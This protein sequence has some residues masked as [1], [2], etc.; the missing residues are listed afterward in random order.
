MRLI[1]LICALVAIPIL[2]YLSLLRV[3]WVA[4]PQLEGKL[5]EGQFEWQGKLRS[6]TFFLPEKL[7]ANPGLVFVLHGSNG[8]SAAAR[9]G[10]AYE[11]DRLS[12]R[13]FIP[14]YPAGFDKHWND[15]RLEGPYEANLQ[16]IDDVGFLR[17]LRE[18]LLAE[19]IADPGRTYVTGISNGGQ[20]VYRLAL[21]APKTFQAYAAVIA[22][23]PAAENMAC[24]AAGEP[25]SMLVMN[26][27]E[28]PMNPYEGGMVGLYGIL[29]KRGH[30]LSTQET[31]KYWRELIPFESEAPEYHEVDRIDDGTAVTTRTWRY[32]NSMTIEQVEVESGGHTVPHPIQKMPGIL[33]KTSGDISGADAIWT[34][35]TREDQFKYRKYKGPVE[36]GHPR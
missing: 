14:V 3:Q 18:K 15:C 8:D 22:S 33:G 12:N 23:L 20:M 27:T 29:G 2:M 16:N 4:E 25:V 26:G 7:P 28:G 24:K 35:F 19:L 21:E 30:V 17:A 5:V 9:Q 32:P 10:F 36:S 34:F 11:F 31:V 1:L 13:G 6:Y